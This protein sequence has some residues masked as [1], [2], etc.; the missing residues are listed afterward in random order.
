MGNKG[1]S[2]KRSK[3]FSYFDNLLKNRK[4][5]TKEI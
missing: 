4:K 5:V 1:A 2:Y 3:C